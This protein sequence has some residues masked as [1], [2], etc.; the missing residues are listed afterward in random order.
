MA[1]GMLC[2]HVTLCS[3]TGTGLKWGGFFLLSTQEVQ[4]SAVCP[5]PESA[6]PAG[7]ALG[8]SEACGNLFPVSNPRDSGGS[9]V[10]EAVLSSAIPQIYGDNWFMLQHHWKNCLSCS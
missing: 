1:W 2:S 9:V 8:P 6:A 4:D 3:C 10:E 7:P 5:E